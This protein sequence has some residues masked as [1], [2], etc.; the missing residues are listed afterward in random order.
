MSSEKSVRSEDLPGIAQRIVASDAPS[1]VQFRGL[2]LLLQ[3]RFGAGSLA[4]IEHGESSDETGD[5][6]H[7]PTTSEDSL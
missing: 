3:S 5:Y 7:P 1:H 6:P 4:V 2:L